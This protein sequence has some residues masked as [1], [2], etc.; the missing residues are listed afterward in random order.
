MSVPGSEVA[1][2]TLHE[3]G[4]LGGRADPHRRRT[5]HSTEVFVGVDVAKARNVIA[6]AD[7][8]R[9]GEVRI[10]DVDQDL[11]MRQMRR[12]GLRG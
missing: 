4:L 6:I 12:Q 2:P 10:L 11:D 7:G 9:G 5:D 3:R 8:E 1:R